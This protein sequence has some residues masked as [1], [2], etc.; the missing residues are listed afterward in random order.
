MS[1]AAYKQA[2]EQGWARLSG[3]LL[4][5]QGH[6]ILGEASEA[7]VTRENIEAHFGGMLDLMYENFKP[8]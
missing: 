3:L 7:A 5:Y 6:A 1:P 8:K 4:K 2:V